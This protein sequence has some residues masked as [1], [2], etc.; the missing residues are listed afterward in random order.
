MNINLIDTIPFTVF[1]FYFYFIFFWGG[2]GGGGA[3]GGG[4]GAQHSQ[5]TSSII[6]I[7]IDLSPYVLI[8]IVWYSSSVKKTT[9]NYLEH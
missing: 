8:D 7:K 9:I 6:V 3:G 4:G 2:G 5:S 1:N